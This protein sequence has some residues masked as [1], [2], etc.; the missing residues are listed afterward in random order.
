MLTNLFLKLKTSLVSN[1]T[2]DN[3]NNYDCKPFL[4]HFF[5]VSFKDLKVLKKDLSKVSKL[6]DN[7]MLVC[8][9]LKHPM[10]RKRS[11]DQ[12]CKK[13]AAF[14]LWRFPSMYLAFPVMLGLLLG[15]SS[16]NS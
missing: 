12:R 9:S 7:V 5:H 3:N 13:K 1:T 4:Q 11:N 2:V 8:P 15:K 14:Y 10:V 16:S 6:F